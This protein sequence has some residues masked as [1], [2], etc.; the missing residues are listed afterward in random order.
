MQLEHCETHELV[1]KNPSEYSWE[2][3]M[4]LPD[5]TWFCSD[6][7]NYNV[8]LQRAARGNI[9]STARLSLTNQDVTFNQLLGR[10][11]AGHEHRKP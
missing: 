1:L 6:D 3:V 10:C 11:D 7:K 8:I 4:F 2:S 9:V 5:Q